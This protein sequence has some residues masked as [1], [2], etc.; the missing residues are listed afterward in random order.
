VSFEG[1]FRLDG[2]F[3]GEISERGTL[4]VSESAV[5]KA[6]I[7]VN[8]IVIHGLVVGHVAIP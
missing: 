3:N 8:A 2:R 5:V 6:K 1:V 4:I 7:E